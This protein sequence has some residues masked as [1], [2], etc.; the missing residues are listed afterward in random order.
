M[1]PITV[2]FVIYQTMLEITTQMKFKTYKKQG[3]QQNIKD[4]NNY[5]LT[6]STREI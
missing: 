3:E 2:K 1:N 4:R 5:S 6:G